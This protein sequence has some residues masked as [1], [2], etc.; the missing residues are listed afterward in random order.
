MNEWVAQRPASG[1]YPAA[2]AIAL[3]PDF[4]SR[5]AAWLAR[6]RAHERRVKRRLLLWAALLAMAVAGVFEFVRS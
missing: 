5:W 4:D 3:D 6:G 2:P 1:G